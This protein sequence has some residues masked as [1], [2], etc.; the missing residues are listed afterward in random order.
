MTTR[1][2]DYG[3]WP[4]LGQVLGGYLH[5]DWDLEA[6]SPDDALRLARVE[7]EE[8]VSAAIEQIN[9]LLAGNQ[10]DA[11]L[12]EIVE[13]MSAGYSPILDG[14]TIRAWLV[15]AKALLGGEA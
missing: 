3:R 11:E 12:T 15:H 10:S 7:S 6:D 2:T 14:W 4:E 8:Q 13:R 5:Q 1:A 9:E